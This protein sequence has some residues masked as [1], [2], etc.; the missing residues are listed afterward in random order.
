MVQSQE[1]R[2]LRR[3]T[4]TVR[5][6]YHL[7]DVNRT[8][9]QEIDK[10][11]FPELIPHVDPPP[12]IDVPSLLKD[13][14][15]P[16]ITRTPHSPTSLLD[17]PQ[18][19]IPDT[20]LDRQTSLK[21]SSPT[22]SWLIY[23]DEHESSAN[24]QPLSHLLPLLST[25]KS[26]PTSGPLSA[27]YAQPHRQIRSR[28]VKPLSKTSLLPRLPIP[29]P[30]IRLQTNPPTARRKQ[31]NTANS[32]QRQKTVLPVAD[33]H[34]LSLGARILRFQ[35]APH[36]LDAIVKTHDAKKQQRIAS[37][38]VN[39]VARNRRF[40]AK[41]ASPNQD[42]WFEQ[43]RKRQEEAKLRCD[44]RREEMA[45][46]IAASVDR[47]AARR[48]E[49]ELH[50]ERHLLAR[51]MLCYVIVGKIAHKFHALYRASEG[52]IL[53][54]Q[55]HRATRR[56]QYFWR[57]KSQARCLSHVTHA[58]LVIQKSMVKWYHRCRHRKLCQAVQII[59][60]SVEEFQ[61]AKFRRCIL[62]YRHCIYKFQSMFRGWASI[63]EARTKLLLLYWA[64]V[65]KSMAEKTAAAITN[66]LM[67]SAIPEIANLTP[68][69]RPLS[70]RRA[71][72]RLPTPNGTLPIGGR[73]G[74]GSPTDFLE[75][76]NMIRRGTADPSS[77]N[78]ARATT[79]RIPITLK[80][81]L[82]KA[83]LRQKRAEFLGMKPSYREKWQTQLEKRRER[84]V[85]MDALTIVALDSLRFEKSLFLMLQSIKEDEMIALV[86]EAEAKVK[87][88][89]KH[90]LDDASTTNQQGI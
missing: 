38:G 82:L 7:E 22:T 26:P 4:F 89:E 71:S 88:T 64:K 52:R 16:R 33:P 5:D 69:S 23:R 2:R 40:V 15:T 83:M 24:S 62:K 35:I 34:A 53:M 13:I 1:E 46:T 61:E 85:T 58:L 90:G 55:Q 80:V 75:H 45:K 36:E 19:L 76:M 28:P 72:I 56:I 73:A 68:T 32:L 6:G 86:K 43:E 84:G 49:E 25:P 47:W 48:K 29:S 9:N 60:T 77:R 41:N 12:Q 78:R 81:G 70:N 44:R 66:D 67:Q 65:E 42:D 11:F 39:L 37:H 18:T 79:S 63:T 17:C 3:S 10:Q 30:R 54:G 59:V 14:A 20:P 8:K 31:Y 27:R 87:A 57:R 50:R 74:F 51:K 21:L